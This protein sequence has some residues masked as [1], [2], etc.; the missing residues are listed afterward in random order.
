V[1]RDREATPE[2]AAGKQRDRALSAEEAATNE[3]NKAVAAGTQAIQERNRAV[4]EKGRADA[5]AAS[6]KAIS[7]FLQGDVLPQAS[8]NTQARPD[9]KPDPDLQIRT[10]LDRAAAQTLHSKVLEVRRRVLGEEHTATLGSLNKVAIVYEK[11]GQWAQ[12]E[13][14]QSK[15]LEISRRVLG[16]EHYDTLSAMISLAVV[17]LGQRQYAQAEVLDAKAVEIMGRVCPRARQRRSCLVRSSIVWRP[18]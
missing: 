7:D 14:I 15:V 3:R 13:A 8:A 11:Q 17:R 2:G 6:A 16:E 5:E 4:A 18:W 1:E 12:A 10:A 9:I